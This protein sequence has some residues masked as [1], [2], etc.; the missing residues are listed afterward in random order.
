MPLLRLW[1]KISRSRRLNIKRVIYFLLILYAAYILIDSFITL[2]IIGFT[3]SL[4]YS[5]IGKRRY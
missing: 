4:L 3:I 1:K 5:L 2:F